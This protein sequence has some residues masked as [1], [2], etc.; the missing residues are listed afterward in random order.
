MADNSHLT[1][2]RVLS[3]E[4]TSP[5][6]PA[7]INVEGNFNMGFLGNGVLTLSGGNTFTG[8]IGVNNSIL[9]IASIGDTNTDNTLGRSAP[10]PANFKLNGTLRYIGADATPSSNRGFTATAATGSNSNLEIQNS[11]TNLTLSGEVRS[12]SGG[13]QKTGPGS[14]TFTNAGASNVLASEGFTVSQGGVAFN[15]GTASVYQVVG[16]TIIDTASSLSI[17]SGKLQSG[18]YIQAQN[19]STET[20]SGSSQIVAAGFGLV[21]GSSATLSGTATILSTAS[22]GV[23]TGSVLNLNSTG[24]IPDDFDGYTVKSSNLLAVG[25]DTPG[26][27][28]AVNITAGKVFAPILWLGNESGNLGSLNISG[29]GTFVTTA[30]ALGSLNAGANGVG[31]IS[32]KGG[33]LK[34]NY[35]LDTMYIGLAGDGLLDVSAGTMDCT[36]PNA[37]ASHPGDALWIGGGIGIPGILNVRGTG[38]VTNTTNVIRMRSSGIINVGVSG[39]AHGV[40]QTAAIVPAPQEAGSEARVGVVNFHGGTLTATVDA[41]GVTI[42]EGGTD[43]QPRSDRQ[44]R[45]GCRSCVCLCRRRENRYQRT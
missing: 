38:S 37:G 25:F 31:Y 33:T 20:I 36:T 7:G 44:R 30:T 27:T 18:G 24:V 39:D 29:T 10:I 41:D 3:D 14:A 12:T 22:I 28:G 23:H 34:P 26:T 40:L 19:G 4:I 9:E 45:V 6:T 16:N 5:S 15:G 8:P 13:L 42:P 43:S 2:S 32:I 21:N 11:S 1:L 35:A 17:S